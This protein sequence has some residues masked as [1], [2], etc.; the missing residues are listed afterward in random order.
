[1]RITFLA[2]RL[3]PAVC[4]VADHTLLLAEAM[5]GEGAEVSFIH[6]EPFTGTA[7]SLPG[8]VCR[9]EGGAE[10]LAACLARQEADWLWVQFSNYGYSRFGAPYRLWR[11][12]KQF[13]QRMPNV[14]IAL[15]M[16]E[17]HCLPPQLGVKGPI[18]SPWQRYTV[19]AV[20][21]L[22]DLIFVS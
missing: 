7:Q 17:T 19:G 4:G 1:M 11:E 21:R 9:W 8:P 13:R 10:A 2:P 14:R 16:H 12:L 22:G 3:P 20:T 18:L 5:I 15:Y 6:R